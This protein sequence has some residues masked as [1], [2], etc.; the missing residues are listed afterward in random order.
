MSGEVLDVLSEILYEASDAQYRQQLLQEELQRC[1]GFHSKLIFQHISQ[2]SDSIDVNNLHAYLER[3]NP[4]LGLSIPGR[5]ELELAILHITEHQSH[6]VMNLQHFENFVGRQV[7]GSNQTTKIDLSNPR[8]LL[9]STICGLFTQEAQS[10]LRLNNLRKQMTTNEF[11]EIERIFELLDRNKKGFLD[12]SD[13]VEFMISLSGGRPLQQGEINGRANRSFQRLDI[14]KDGKVGIWDWKTSLLAIEASKAVA[15][16][17]HYPTSCPIQRHQYSN[18]DITTGR[19]VT[20]NKT[21]PGP[22]NVAPNSRK[23]SYDYQLRKNHEISQ[24]VHA[25]TGQFAASNHFQTPLT[26]VTR[27]VL[28]GGQ[29]TTAEMTGVSPGLI[30]RTPK[31]AHIGLVGEESISN[32]KQLHHSPRHHTST[33]ENYI[34]AEVRMSPQRIVTNAHREYKSSLSR[35]E[36]VHNQP[37]FM[38]AY[39]ADFV[40]GSTNGKSLISNTRVSPRRQTTNTVL[41]RYSSKQNQLGQIAQNQSQI[42]NG[43]HKRTIDQ[44]GFNLSQTT[45]TRKG[46]IADSSVYEEIANVTHPRIDQTNVQTDVR[47]QHNVNGTVQLKTST[48]VDYE[49]NAASGRRS[50]VRFQGDQLPNLDY[51]SP[52]LYSR[53]K[54][55][56]YSPRSKKSLVHVSEDG[57]THTFTSRSVTHDLSRVPTRQTEIL[58]PNEE[59]LV[60]STLTELLHDYRLVEKDKIE[61]SLRSD[62]NIK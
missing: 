1:Q 46:K 38:G 18:V 54:S 50:R 58:N 61:L 3:N 12:I 23:T 31:T 51:D 8:S 10:Q 55:P 9:N 30:S 62:F 57:L 40:P 45:S 59:A 28:P 16:H 17:S 35:G 21:R 44:P 34:P 52:S 5:P 13:I 32:I 19:V 47:Y 6:R 29:I 26:K 39:Q 7:Y 33:V 27:E 53:A 56:V 20:S 14:D 11:F 42:D 37:S 24:H 36:V 60:F 48:N 22:Q 43:S 25:G 41:N 2:K 15:S 4:Q 49:S